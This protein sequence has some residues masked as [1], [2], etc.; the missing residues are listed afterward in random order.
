MFEL[1]ESCQLFLPQE[2]QV[3]FASAQRPVSEMDEADPTILLR[4]RGTSVLLVEDSADARALLARYI[5]LSGGEVDLAENGLEG[6]KQALSSPY[7]IVLMDIQ[8]PR[9]NGL[10][11]IRK[12][13]DYGYEGSVV[14]VT[15]HAQEAEREQC[16]AAGFDDYL[17]KPVQRHRLLYTVASQP[18]RQR[19]VGSRFLH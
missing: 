1:S 3:E 7:D 13:R 5:R 12:L 4:V 15:G 11:A 19:L 17:T 9:L 16:L 6:I 14:A 10:D 2:P 18:K 8:M